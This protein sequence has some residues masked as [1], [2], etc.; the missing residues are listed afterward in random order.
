MSS[1]IMVDNN[2]EKNNQCSKRS[3]CNSIS[4]NFTSRS[5]VEVVVVDVVVVVVVEVVVVVV[6]VAVEVVEVVEV[7]VVLVAVHTSSPSLLLV[8]K[9]LSVGNLYKHHMSSYI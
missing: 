8:G 3:T 2:E 9:Y 6:E 5:S 7:V 4:C 1:A